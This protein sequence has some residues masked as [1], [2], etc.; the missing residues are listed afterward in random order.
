MALI[1]INL[2]IIKTYTGYFIAFPHGSFAFQFYEFSNKTIIMHNNTAV[3]V[4]FFTC[5]VYSSATPL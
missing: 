3:N 4:E 1:L 2:I 5:P